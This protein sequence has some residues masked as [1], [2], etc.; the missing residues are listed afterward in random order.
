[1]QTQPENIIVIFREEVAPPMRS[2]Y[3]KTI[4]YDIVAKTK[5]GLN[6]LSHIFQNT[7]PRKPDSKYGPEEDLVFVNDV[8]VRTTLLK[9]WQKGYADQIVQWEDIPQSVQEEIVNR[10]A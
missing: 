10:I 4:K 1:M 2:F 3:T 8:P 5:Q 9:V 6:W 7:V